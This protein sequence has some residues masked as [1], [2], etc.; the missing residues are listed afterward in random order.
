MLSP[1]AEDI[2]T[3]ARKTKFLGVETGTRMTIVRL[4]AG[5]LFVHSPVALDDETRREVDALGEVRAVVAPSLFHHLNVRAWMTA[6]PKAVYAACPGLEWKRAD[7][8][9]SCV[10]GDQPHPI[11]ADDLDQVYFSARREN[12]IDF[13][14]PKS[15]TLIVTDALLNLS[16]HPDRSTRFVARLMGNTAPGV[17]WVEPFMVRDRRLAR[18]QLDR[19]LAWD[20]DRVLLAHGALVERDGPEVVRR[21]YRWL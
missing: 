15:R 18:R 7:L 6:Y 14:H 9:W 12:E 8:P 17:G 1:W 4:S 5:G 10:I 11:W 13:Y 2:W 21:A 16:T 20:F 19:I 3:A